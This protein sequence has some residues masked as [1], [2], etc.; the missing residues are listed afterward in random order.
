MLITCTSRCGA[1]VLL[2]TSCCCCSIANGQSQEMLRSPNG[3]L[4]RRH[5][6]VAGAITGTATSFVEGP[7][8]MFKSQVQVQILAERST[9]TSAT[10]SA[11]TPSTQPKYKGVFDC[12][13][14]ITKTYGI[15]GVYQGLSSVLLRNSPATAVY[16]GMNQETRL[17]LAGESRA[18]E[19]LS[20]GE[21]LFAGGVAGFLYWA[22]SY[23]ADVIKVRR[24]GSC[25]CDG[26]RKMPISSLLFPSLLFH[27]HLLT[28]LPRTSCCCCIGVVVIT[29]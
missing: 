1:L 17:L 5:Y 24:S 2:R 16:F 12:A 19:S 23:P 13:R 11:T 27:H 22:L 18:V 20:S 21:L 3:S 4:E 15:R 10:T 9:T 6:Y 14:I 8:D 26:H 29:I 28:Y 7:I 25:L